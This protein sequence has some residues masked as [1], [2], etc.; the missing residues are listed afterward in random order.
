MC[1]FDVL[2]SFCCVW[3]CLLICC[4]F[5]INVTKLYVD[6]TLN[7]LVV[8]PTSFIT[9][10][11]GEFSVVAADQMLLGEIYVFKLLPKQSGNTEVNG[12]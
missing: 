8:K 6:W 1:I 10:I 4:F 2:Y 5:Y 11:F 7:E 3:F 12:Y 9:F